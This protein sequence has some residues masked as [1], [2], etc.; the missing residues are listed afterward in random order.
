MRQH[1]AGLETTV[2]TGRALSAPGSVIYGQYSQL[3]SKLAAWV[4][5]TLEWH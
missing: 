2:E 5:R 3:P 4:W 1:M